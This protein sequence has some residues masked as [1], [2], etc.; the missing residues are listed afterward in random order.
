M[1]NIGC[2]MEH[3]ANKCQQRLS[4]VLP[5]VRRSITGKA[6]SHVSAGGTTGPAESPP[7]V[8]SGQHR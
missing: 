7:T 6:H 3:C 1:V 5:Q 2:G 4:Q 8:R